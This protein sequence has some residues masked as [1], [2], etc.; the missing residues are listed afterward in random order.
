VGGG[1]QYPSLSPDGQTVLYWNATNDVGLWDVNTGEPRGVIRRAKSTGSRFWSAD[2]KRLYIVD[3]TNAIVVVE[4]ASAKVVR[5][6][7][8][9]VEANIDRARFAFSR[10]EKWFA[11]DGGPG[12]TEIKVRN[13]QTGAELRTLRGHEERAHLL[14]FNPDGSRLLTADFGGTV[15]L[16]DVATGRE[17]ATT[18]FIG[19]YIN[20]IEFSPDGKRVAVTGNLRR[21]LSGEAWIVDAENLREVWSL[22][23]HTLNVTDAVFSP[24]GQRLATSSADRTI[25]LWDLRTGQEILKLKDSWGM[26]SLRFVSDGRRLMS[27]SF[28]GTIRIWDATPLPE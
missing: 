28:D 2:G 18:K 11:Q 7:Q 13:L 26:M 1:L 9:D 12:A 8:I 5:K 16:W 25:R 19:M 17:I 27:A 22:K 4:V 21:L 23:G 6:L 14:E 24:D 10:D 15:K 3:E 20:G